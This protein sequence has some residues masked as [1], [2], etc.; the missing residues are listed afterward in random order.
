MQPIT[1]PTNKE[2]QREFRRLTSTK[3]FIKHNIHANG[4]ILVWAMV[5]S[6]GLYYSK[7]FLRSVLSPVGAI[8]NVANDLL[9]PKKK[10]RLEK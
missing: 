5:F 9:F 7:H 10:F 8:G 1:T 2:Q 4:T 3:L 6:P